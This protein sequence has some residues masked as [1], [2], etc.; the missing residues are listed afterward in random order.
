MDDSE[1]LLHVLTVV[2]DA[3]MPLVG[4]YLPDDAEEKSRED[5]LAA[6]KAKWL[7]PKSG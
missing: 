1:T 4:Q 6:V 5:G 3:G 7:P 2:P